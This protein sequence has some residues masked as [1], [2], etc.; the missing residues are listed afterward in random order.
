ML[1]VTRRYQLI[2]KP[3]I[4]CAALAPLLLMF[5]GVAGI[6][7]QS[8]GADPVREVLHRSGKT[9]INLLFATLAVT[10]LRQLLGWPHLLRVRRLLGVF[11]F[12]YAALHLLVYLGLD[13]RFDFGH[14]AQDLT[15]RPYITVGFSGLLILAALAATSTQAMMRRL[16]RRWQTL[17]RWVYAAAVLAAWHFWWQ[18][19]R[20]ITEPLLYATVLGLLL[21]W[22]LWRRRATTSTSVSATVPERT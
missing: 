15:K 20:D 9:A 5:L 18:V 1:S 16:G 10:P 12:F 11:A 17:H 14:L 3:L 4:W 22:R 2:V 13:L 8:L 7:G 6:G 21:G 19:K